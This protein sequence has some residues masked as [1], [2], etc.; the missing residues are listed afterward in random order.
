MTELVTGQFYWV[1]PGFD[2]D[3]DNVADAL[4]G[5]RNRPAEPLGSPSP[6]PIWWGMSNTVVRIFKRE[7]SFEVR[8]S[9]FFYFDDNPGRR[10]INKRMKSE[11]AEAAAR[12][13]AKVQRGDR[14][15][16]PKP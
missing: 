8:V 1:Q 10:A 7:E 9:T 6:G 2:P 16:P 13:Y 4:G 11:A 3:E 15:S 12:A 5:R 14:P